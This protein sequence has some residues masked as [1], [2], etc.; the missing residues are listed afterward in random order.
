MD[1][2]FGWHSIGTVPFAT[3]TVF[4]MREENH[5]YPSLRRFGNLPVLH[6]WRADQ[7]VL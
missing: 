5:L 4:L 3:T 7:W 1:C 6:I 2:V